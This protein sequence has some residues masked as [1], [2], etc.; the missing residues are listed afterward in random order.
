MATYDRSKSEPTRGPMTKAEFFHIAGITTDLEK[1]ISDF[2]GRPEI[3]DTRS[4]NSNRRLRHKWMQFWRRFAE[5]DPCKTN[6][7]RQPVTLNRTNICPST[8]LTDFIDI[9]QFVVQ[10]PNIWRTASMLANP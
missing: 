2:V 9:T 5:V 7:E 10:N 3:L 8:Y 6:W 1:F 4:R